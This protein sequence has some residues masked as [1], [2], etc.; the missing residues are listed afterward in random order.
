MFFKVIDL[1]LLKKKHIF[2][3]EKQFIMQKVYLF[4]FFLFLCFEVSAQSQAV[5]GTKFQR[6]A[7]RAMEIKRMVVDD[8]S[9]DYVV[10]DG[11]QYKWF[12][13]R[14]AALDYFNTMTVKHD[15][16]VVYIDSAEV[17]PAEPDIV[18]IS[19]PA[20]RKAD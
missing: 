7:E 18:T 14:D 5:T 6:T 2:N 1:A 16:I 15:M 4:G 20:I 12:V 3:A 11:K 10:V 19:E 9:V 13:N 17:D 8:K